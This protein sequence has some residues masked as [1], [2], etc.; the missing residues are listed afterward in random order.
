MDI[1]R[2]KYII[3]DWNGTLIDDAWLSFKLLNRTLLQHGIDAISFSDYQRRFCHPVRSF[4]E[5]LGLSVD[6]AAFSALCYSFHSSY[7]EHF[8]QCE[9]HSYARCVLEKVS[10]SDSSQALLSAFPNAD[11]KP[12]LDHFKLSQLFDLSCGQDNNLAV[13]KTD[14]ARALVSELGYRQDNLLFIGDTLHD[15]EVAKALNA[16]CLL[17]GNGYQD[18]E[19]LKS[20]GFPVVR[21]L[22]EVAGA[23]HVL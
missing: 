14:K 18:Y 23:I 11:L 10:E 8:K 22:A 5:L 15:A 3:W 19:L 9:L 2:Y 20:S 13:G 16:D 6:D 7:S 1:T 4:Y 12:V 21:S 17:I